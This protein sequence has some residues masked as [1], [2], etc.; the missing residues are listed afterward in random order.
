MIAG[1]FNLEIRKKEGFHLV[2]PLSYWEASD[3]EIEKQTGGCGPGGIGDW[4]VPDTMYGE[5]VFLACQIH[6]WMYWKGDTKEDK[7]V[8]D[9]VFLVNMTL[10]VIEDNNTLD[11]LRLRRVMTYFEAVHFG[12][13]SAFESAHTPKKGEM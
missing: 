5:S 11:S 13:Y 7:K 1:K 4:F 3:A 12:G 10:L 2:A 8:A 9:L 6:D